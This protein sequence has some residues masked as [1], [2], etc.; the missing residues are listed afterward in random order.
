MLNFSK[1]AA[2][3]LI[4]I[5]KYHSVNSQLSIQ[6]SSHSQLLYLGKCLKMIDLKKNDIKLELTYVIFQDKRTTARLRTRKRH[7]L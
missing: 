6:L 2:F 7:P 5:T 4:K 1:Q 3:S